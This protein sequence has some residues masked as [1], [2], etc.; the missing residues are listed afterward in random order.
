MFWWFGCA[1]PSGGLMVP[2][3]PGIVASPDLDPD[4]DR[5]EGELV[6][7][8]AELRFGDQVATVLAFDGSVPGPLITVDQ[9]DVV[10]V[11]FRNELPDAYHNSIHWHGIEGYNASDGTPVTQE[12]VPRGDG[13]TYAFVATRPG[14]YWYHPHHRGAQSVF[15]GLY[16]PLL[17][18]EPAEALLVDRGILPRREEVLVLSDVSLYDGRVLSAESDN[19]MEVMNGTEGELLLV[20]GQVLPTLR[21][22]VGAGLRLRVVNT[23]ITRFWRLSVRGHTLYRVGG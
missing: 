20:N 6:A 15:S 8:E 23:S 14:L 3:S 10:D 2:E 7:A 12:M 1:P 22:E 9:G 17:V 5:F 13:F 16:G 11:R 19:P 21:A 4:P 18:R